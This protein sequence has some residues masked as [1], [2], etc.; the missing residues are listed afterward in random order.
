MISQANKR[1]RAVRLANNAIRYLARGLGVRGDWWRAL[2]IE[3]HYNQK[4][5]NQVHIFR[6]IFGKDKK[7]FSQMSLFSWKLLFK[8]GEAPQKA[9][10]WQGWAGCMYVCYTWIRTYNF[11]S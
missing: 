1:G 11:T 6:S 5:N 3:V 7:R 4:C 10:N 2:G 8:I 9:V